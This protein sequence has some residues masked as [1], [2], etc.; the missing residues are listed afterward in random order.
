M[1]AAVRGG[2]AASNAVAAEPP[3]PLEDEEDRTGAN[4]R[5]ANRD[6]PRG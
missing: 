1:G 2:V 3:M 4:R 5:A 6:R